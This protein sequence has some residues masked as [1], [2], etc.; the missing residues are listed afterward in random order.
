LA[1]CL[2]PKQDAEG[3][4]PFTRSQQC[5]K[6]RVTRPWLVAFLSPIRDIWPGRHYGMSRICHSPLTRVTR[7]EE[8]R[9]DPVAGLDV[10][11]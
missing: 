1:E 8:E 2:L 9:A 3:S 10:L 4:S 6:P 11:P 7:A 5:N